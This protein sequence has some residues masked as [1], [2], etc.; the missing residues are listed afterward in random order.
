MWR[1]N[2]KK[3]IF[4]TDRTVELSGNDCKGI[5]YKSDFKRN[6][7]AMERSNRLPKMGPRII[8]NTVVFCAKSTYCYSVTRFS[9]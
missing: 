9:R 8:S 6:C 1:N 5:V 7:F 4:Q 3:G 2:G